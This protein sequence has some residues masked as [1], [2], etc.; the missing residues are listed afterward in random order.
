MWSVSRTF[1][2]PC[3]PFIWGCQW[4]FGDRQFRR[5]CVNLLIVL[6]NSQCPKCLDSHLRQLF[7]VKKYIFLPKVKFSLFL[8]PRVTNIF[9][10]ITCLTVCVLKMYNLNIGLISTKPYNPWKFY[11]YHLCCFPLPCFPLSCFQTM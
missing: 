2:S 10:L 1:S 9:F 11:G 5:Q 4:R 6:P 7:N 3:P 8:L